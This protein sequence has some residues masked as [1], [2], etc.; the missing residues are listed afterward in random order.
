MKKSKPLNNKE[1][2]KYSKLL[3]QKLET[4]GLID[5]TVDIRLGTR[6]ILF[7][8]TGTPVEAA[9]IQLRNPFRNLLKRVRRLTKFEVESFLAAQIPVQRK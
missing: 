9:V 6:K 7:E 2:K 1:I 3:A 8:P 5:K 4:L